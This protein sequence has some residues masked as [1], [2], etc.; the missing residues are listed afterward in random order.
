[1][2]RRRSTG[3]GSANRLKI[4]VL[5]EHE[6]QICLYFRK[7]SDNSPMGMKIHLNLCPTNED[8]FGKN[9]LNLYHRSRITFII[10]I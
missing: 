3:K 7:N 9:V 4:S 6:N 8:A 5:V 2:R 1:M 10:Q